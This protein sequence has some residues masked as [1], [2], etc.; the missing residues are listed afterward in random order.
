MKLSKKCEY[1]LKALTRLSDPQAPQLISI[2]EL[3]KRE[4][5]PKKFLE[6]V[7]LALKKA[8]IL[9]SSRGKTGGYALH[10]DPTKVTLGDITRAVDG[11]LTP[12]PCVSATAPVKCP[13]C[14]NLDN[15]WLRAVMQEVGEGMAAVLDQITVAEICRRAAQSQYRERHTITYDI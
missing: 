7:L 5:I 2:Q 1:A 4:K 3:A 13:D 8:G 11:P 14:A 10:V 12:L 9:Q 6:Q 15:C